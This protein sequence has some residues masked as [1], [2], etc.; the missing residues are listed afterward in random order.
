MSWSRHGILKG[1][2]VAVSGG[3]SI[4]ILC[5]HQYTRVVHGIA[6]W[7]GEEDALQHLVA[8]LNKLKITEETDRAYESIEEFLET[9]H[10]Q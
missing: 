1:W 5:C 9:T 3:D 4:A 7:R 2:M 8:N 6:Y 10:A